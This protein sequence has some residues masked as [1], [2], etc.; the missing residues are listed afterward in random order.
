[1]SAL[2][3]SN[4]ARSVP[5]DTID[6][7]LDGQLYI[8]SLACARTVSETHPELA[9][10]HMLS[11]CPEM[12]SSGPAHMVLPIQDSEYDNIL[13]HLPAA[14][15]FIENAISAG[16]RVLVH[17]VMGVS[18]S[19]TVIAAYLMKTRRLSPN[20]A[21]CAIRKRR[22]RIFPN[23]GF[24]KQ[25]Y[26]FEACSYVPTRTHPAYRSWKRR[27][28]QDVTQFLNILSDTSVI[29]P[30]KIYL[31]SDLPSDL[32]QATCLVKYMGLSHCLSLSPSGVQPHTL[33][34][35][36]Y[37]VDIPVDS[38]GL[39]HALPTACNYIRSSLSTGGRVLVHSRTE[40]V[41]VLVIT[42][43]L[44]RSRRINPRQA[45]Q[46]VKDALPLFEPTAN[47][48]RHLEKFAS[49]FDY[50]ADSASQSVSMP[51]STSSASSLHMPSSPSAA[52]FAPLVGA[53]KDRAVR[54]M[55][56]PARRVSIAGQS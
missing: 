5:V 33:G 39:I 56:P 3:A 45:V 7:V 52:G 17:C 34:I 42:A 31:N 16:G 40:S 46:M 15:Q 2:A 12:S 6:A 47:F 35:D 28:R 8:S 22:P 55:A 23:Y 27:Q 4:H 41:A 14:C 26:V 50:L 38:A 37:H 21:L 51:S 43:Y 29:L 10:T 30:D 19:A 1:M 49:T 44:M 13:D 48:M 25:L 32:D 53:A 9:I 11:V 54:S 36:Q 24:V 20:Q 18:R